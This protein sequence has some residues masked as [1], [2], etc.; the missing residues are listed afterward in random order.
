MTTI[1]LTIL[2]F[3]A[4]GAGVVLGRNYLAN[5]RN[6]P[7]LI[8]THLLLGAGALEQLIINIQGDRGGSF[9]MTAA[10]LLAITLALGFGASLIAR[11]SASK[12]RFVVAVHAAAGSVGF[13]LF[14][15]WLS[16][17]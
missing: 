14:L 1:P 7:V 17:V 4:V 11:Q 6:K 15:A 9:G 3:G 12:A 13:L 16:T 5:I 8:A 2:L 10:G